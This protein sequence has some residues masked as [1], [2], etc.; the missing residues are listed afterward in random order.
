MGRANQAKHRLGGPMGCAPSLLENNNQLLVYQLAIL[1]LKT[2]AYIRHTRKTASLVRWLL[3]FFVV[4]VTPA[5]M[6]Q[7]ATEAMGATYIIA[8]GSCKIN[9]GLYTVDQVTRVMSETASSNG[10]PTSIYSHPA[11]V[12]SYPVLIKYLGSNCEL[13]KAQQTS[14]AIWGEVVSAMQRKAGQM[15]AELDRLNNSSSLKA[16]S[17]RYCEKTA[18]ERLVELADMSGIGSPSWKALAGLHRYVLIRAGCDPVLCGFDVGVSRIDL[19]NSLS[20]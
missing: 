11:I 14:N 6:A 13:T 4:P 16:S 7:E 8:W 17:P 1:G 10:W 5:A 18:R 15:Q 19:E 3:F 12:A 2:M 20:R 9:S